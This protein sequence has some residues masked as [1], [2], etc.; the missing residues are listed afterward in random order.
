[1]DRI[2]SFDTRESLQVALY[3]TTGLPLIVAVTGV[4]V[5]AGQMSNATA[6]ILVAAGAISVLI[7]PMLAGFLV[8]RSPT[9]PGDAH[10]GV[11]A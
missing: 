3:S 1:Y 10:E 11:S 6:S 7:L 2:S 5:S 4:A 8:R 9:S